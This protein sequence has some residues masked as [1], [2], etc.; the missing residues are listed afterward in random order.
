M[1]KEAGR[2]GPKRRRGCVVGCLVVAAAFIAAAAVG[3]HLWLNWLNRPP[4]LPA[5]PDAYLSTVR[6][7]AT[8]CTQESVPLLAAQIDAESHWNPD[9]DSGQ[10]QGIAQFYPSTWAEWGRD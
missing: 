6:G 3:I 4:P 7:A 5:V 9:A 2:T 8:T 1:E 10:A